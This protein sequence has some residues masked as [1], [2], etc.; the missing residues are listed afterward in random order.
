MQLSG[1]SVFPE[2]NELQ[3]EWRL[4]HGSSVQEQPDYR[5]ISY[6]WDFNS[7]EYASAAGT[8]NN[9]FFRDLDEKSDEGAVDFSM[10]V[11]IAGKSGRLKFGGVYTRGDRSYEEKRYRWSQQARP[12]EII[13]NYPNPVG[14]QDITDDQVTFG[15]TISNITGTL[16][17]Y[18]ADQTLWGLYAMV[19]LELGERWRTIFGL[20]AEHTGMSTR[21][22]EGS[23]GFE[24]ADIN[25][26]DLLPALSVVYRLSKDMN[27]RAAYGRTIARPLYRELASVRVEDAF[28]DEFYAGNP[29]L[30]LSTIDNL[31]L[32]WEWFP[33]TGEIVAASVF[34]KNF[35][36]P[37]EVALVPSIGS[38]QPQNVERG[39]VAGVEFEYRKNLAGLSE[40]LRDFSV[41]MNFSV[42]DSAVSIPEEEL[43]SIRIYDPDASDTRELLGQ[44]PYLVNF[45]LA[46]DN[47]TWGTGVTVAYNVFG[48]R[49][50]LVTS[51]ALPDVYERSLHSLDLIYTQRITRDLRLKFQA[52]N[53]LNADRNKSLRNAG[54]E[55][56]FE[57]YTTGRSFSLG[58]S[59]DFF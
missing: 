24:A 32:R 2:W 15:N 12:Y 54:Q 39:R 50:S 26:T 5:T 1:K 20:R 29:N 28:N 11:E 58:L 4:A 57:Q 56:Y 47:L 44:S 30:E 6:F 41:G 37:I 38:I 35:D 51:G 8:G 22:P 7:Q 16:T 36:R 13:A 14:V 49:L 42:I 59:Y 31:D 25:Q 52:K 43:E 55:Y 33:R 53:I 9:R 10:P 45:E 46:Y 34:Y 27:I 17:D 40:F 3:V 21:A 23:A 18:L 48:D 19:D